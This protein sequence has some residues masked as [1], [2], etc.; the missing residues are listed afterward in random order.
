MRE[1]TRIVYITV[2]NRCASRAGTDT[3]DRP[4]T[5]NRVKR[6]RLRE[7]RL[8][9][10][11]AFFVS[12]TGMLR[13]TSEKGYGPLFGPDKGHR[14]MDTFV[15]NRCRESFRSGLRGRP[16]M[17]PSMVRLIRSGTKVC[18]TRNDS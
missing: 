10:P 12:R 16:R 6:R 4:A 2:Y 5:Q 1:N 11:E 18:N 3:R 8:P 14:R 13:L 7:K 15:R 9:G 17:E